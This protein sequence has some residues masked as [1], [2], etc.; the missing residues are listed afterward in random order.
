MKRRPRRS[1]RIAMYSLLLGWWLLLDYWHLQA[2]QDNASLW[3]SAVLADPTPRAWVNA[4][5]TVPDREDAIRLLREAAREEP[6]SWLPEAECLPYV[7]LRMNL[8]ILLRDAGKMQE[9]AQ[10]QREARLLAPSLFVG[11]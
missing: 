2:W 4:V 7:D 10:W 1:R 5:R 3:W 8:S 9:S 6:P 11:R